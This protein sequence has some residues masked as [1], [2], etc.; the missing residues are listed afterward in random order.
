MANPIRIKRRTSG[1]SGAPSGLLNA[2]LAFNEV[3]N[4]LYYGFGDTAGSASSILAIAGPGAFLTLSST[5]TITGDKTFS[6]NLIAVTQT[7]SDNSTKVATTAFVTSKL[8]NLTNV[9]NTFNTRTGNVTLTSSD[10]TTALAYTP[11][12][13][14]NPSVT[15]TLAVSGDTTITGNLTVNGTTVTINSTTVNVDD[16]NIE[17]GAVATPTDTTADGG[18]ITLK[19]ATDKTINWFSATGAWTLSEN[20]TI[21]SG[22][23][24]RINGVSVLT[25]SALGSGITGSSLTSVGTIATGTWQGT[26]V[27]LAYGGTGATTASAARTNLGLVIGTDILGT[28]TTIDG[29]TF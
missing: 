28:S 3:D 6:G 14:T 21:A 5:Q 13:N 7:G 22:K 16:K 19:G 11:L 8:S 18:G 10:V 20:V 4:T 24:Y 12:T 25:S 2:E 27:G 15:G 26:A 29:G 1:A 17:L 23:E 9:V